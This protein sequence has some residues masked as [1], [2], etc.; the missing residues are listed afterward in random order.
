M[1]KLPPVEVEVE[2]PQ[3]LTKRQKELLAEFEKA[4]EA[5]KTSPR[6]FG[7]VGRLKEFFEDL[8]G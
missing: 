3:H 5:K 6:T 8:K 7:F 4:G 2:T 1:D